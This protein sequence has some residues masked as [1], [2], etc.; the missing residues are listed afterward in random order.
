MV[1]KY[2]KTTLHAWVLNIVPSV[3]GKFEKQSLVHS[4]SKCDFPWPKLILRI[5]VFIIIYR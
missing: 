3:A 5:S 4:P 1:L 2:A